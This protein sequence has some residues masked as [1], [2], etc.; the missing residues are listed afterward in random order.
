MFI[1]TRSLWL[2]FLSLLAAP[3]L[4]AQ[5]SPEDGS[6]WKILFDGKS[7]T[8]LKGVQKSD[9]LRNGWKIADGALNLTKTIKETGRVTG[10]DLATADSF[11]D[12]EFAF[13][14]KNSVSGNSGVLY[15]NRSGLGQKPAGNEFQII[16]DVR[17][18]D[19]L[20]GGPI[21]RTGSLY[22]V[23]PA[24]ET[25]RLND[26]DWNEGRIVVRSNQVQHWINGTKVLEYT[27]G[28]ELAKTAAASGIKPPFG[29]GTKNKSP[30]F[31]LDQG[32]EVSFRNLKIRPLA[33]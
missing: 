29:F 20:K 4:H 11:T 5:S 9:F 25:P 24:A 22:G 12:F 2:P 28:P 14:W 31:L 26:G 13:E 3:L 7:V 23:L 30:V 27:L 18:P 33:P 8:G 16:D 19:G 21:R 6:P 15:F 32:D 10:G 1:P 17:N